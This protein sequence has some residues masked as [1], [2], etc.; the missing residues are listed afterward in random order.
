LNANKD[1]ES[2]RLAI[3]VIPN[4]GRNEITGFKEGVLQVRIA[5]PPEKGKAN[6]ELTDF[7]SET[8]GMKKSSILIIKGQTSRNK[9]I[10]IEGMS[11]DE[12]LKRI[13]T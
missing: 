4:A 3:K 10:V 7:L 9:I 2:I 6:K 12:V 8:L 13:Q 11:G 5:A 1:S